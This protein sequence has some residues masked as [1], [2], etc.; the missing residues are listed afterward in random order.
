MIKNLPLKSPGFCLKIF[1][2]VVDFLTLTRFYP[3]LDFSTSVFPNPRFV[4]RQLCAFCHKRIITNCLM[5]PTIAIAYT[6]IGRNAPPYAVNTSFIGA[7]QALNQAHD[8]SSRFGIIT[9]NCVQ[10][11][12]LLGGRVFAIW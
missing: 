8:I 7:G 5:L 12:A 3:G 10:Q 9:F 1:L 2:I 4:E 6:N 11:I